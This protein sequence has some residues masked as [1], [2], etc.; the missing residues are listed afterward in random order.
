MGK[1]D[2]LNNC[3]TNLAT[4][5]I[6]LITVARKLIQQGKTHLATEILVLIM[7]VSQKLPVLKQ[8]FIA[9]PGI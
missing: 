7:V 9:T 8:L 5:V 3:F 1:S 6:Y 2:L 4:V